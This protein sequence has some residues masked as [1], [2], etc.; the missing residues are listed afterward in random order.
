MNNALRNLAQETN[1]QLVMRCK[2]VTVD[3]ELEVSV[4]RILVGGE[5]TRLERVAIL[6]T[7]SLL[8]Q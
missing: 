7:T 6:K 1:Q 2:K 4:K 8:R 5:L 3:G